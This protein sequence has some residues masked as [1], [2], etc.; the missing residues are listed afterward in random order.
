VAS[1]QML[2]LPPQLLSSLQGTGHDLQ[3]GVMGLLMEDSSVLRP[4]GYPP[5]PPRPPRPSLTP[6]PPSPPPLL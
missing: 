4:G 6:S 2:P 1:A 3:S 5:P